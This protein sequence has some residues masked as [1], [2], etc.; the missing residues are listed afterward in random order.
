MHSRHYSNL[1]FS[2]TNSKVCSMDRADMAC[3]F[4][5]LRLQDS[6]PTSLTPPLLIF[7]S[8]FTY[9]GAI[10]DQFSLIQSGF[11]SNVCPTNNCALI[12][13]VATTSVVVR[14]C[15]VFD[16]RAER[17]MTVS[18]TNAIIT[19]TTFRDNVIPTSPSNAVL[20]LSSNGAST[21]SIQDNV[22]NNSRAAYEISSQGFTGG[23]PD[24]M[25]VNASFNFFV[26][27]TSEVTI[28]NR[29]Y[30]D[31]EDPNKPE[32]PFIPYLASD[33]V[34]ECSN[35]CTDRGV[36]V[37][38]AVV[39]FCVCDDGWGGSECQFPSCQR[40]NHCSGNGRCIAADNCDCDE[41]WLGVSCDRA[42]CTSRNECNGNG[43]CPLPD[44]CICDTSGGYTGRDCNDCLAGYRMIGAK[45]VECSICHNGGT[46]NDEAKCDCTGGFGGDDC[47]ICRENFFGDQCQALP[48]LESVLPNESLDE[49]ETTVRLI[50]VN[51]GLGG[52]SE[53]HCV[54]A[55]IGS[56]EAIEFDGELRCRTPRVDVGSAGVIESAI[57][58]SVD[59]Q[60]SFNSLS[61]TFYG[62][63][64]EGQCINGFCS[65]G[66]CRCLYGYRGD[67]CDE[68]L[69]A[70][71]IN[72]TPL[73][74]ILES[75]SFEHQLALKEGSEPVSWALIGLPPRG[76]SI[77]IDTGRFHWDDPQADSS[78]QKVT[79]QVQN[80]LTSS[81]IILRFHVRASYY[82]KVSTDAVGL[83][84]PSPQMTFSFQTVDALTH[85]LLPLRLAQLWIR[86]QGSLQSRST[87][88]RTNQFGVLEGT[89]QP[90]SND[91]G[92]F[93]YGAQH[94]T[95]KNSTVQGEFS[96][97][98]ISV[99][100]SSFFFRGLVGDTETVTDAFKFTFFGG[101]FSGIELAIAPEDGISLN[102]TLSSNIS[103]ET[104][105]QVFAGFSVNGEYTL[106][107][108]IPV[109]LKTN[110]GIEVSFSIY[111]DIRDRSPRLQLSPALIDVLVVQGGAPLYKDVS[112]KN[113]GSRGSDRID[114]VVPDQ[115][116]IRAVTDS[117]YP[118]LNVEEETT[119][120]FV[121][122]A[123]EDIAIGTVFE[124][125][126]GFQSRQ[127]ASPLNYR[128]TVVSE[129]PAVLT[130]VAT[131]EATYFT[132]EE[133]NLAN[134]TIT[135][136]NVNIGSSF[137]KSSGPSGT[138]VFDELVEG[139]YEVVA[140]KLGHQTFRQT[141]FLDSP[142]YTVEA[143]IQAA[144]VSYTF[145]V[146]PVEVL[147]KYI[148]IVE[149]TFETNVPRPVVV[150]EPGRLDWEGLRNGLYD[151]VS[152]T[153]TNYGLIAANDL[154]YRFFEYWE[155]VRFILPDAEEDP[156]Y[157]RNLGT[158][159]ANSSIVFTVEVEQLIQFDVPPDM[160]E[161]RVGNNV[162]FAPYDK[163]SYESGAGFI[164]APEDDPLDGQ[165][166][167]K[168]DSLG[169][170]D[171][172]YDFKNKIRYDFIYDDDDIRVEE[173]Y[174]ATISSASRR[175][176]GREVAPIPG[177][178][179][180][181][182]SDGVCLKDV[183][184]KCREANDQTKFVVCTLVPIFAV[185]TLPLLA[186]LA[187]V[188]FAVV[189]NVVLA[190]PCKSVCDKAKGKA[191]N[192]PTRSF[193]KHGSN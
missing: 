157:E 102:V 108:S 46:C 59:G 128:A 112:I 170:V 162:I 15:E 58:V 3:R 151:E 41:G 80:Q 57:R 185:F 94:P 124:G 190:D 114:I 159:P 179:V 184:D 155:N 192:L 76:T 47:R 138:A 6:L 148:V 19:E 173:V 187:A 177:R 60:L 36:C 149:T 168:L 55:G 70:P 174:N 31:D 121:F 93:E 85:Q 66:R 111:L 113:I 143:F 182:Q 18:S 72:P 17:I 107:G 160:V 125:T 105:Q 77:D 52:G 119:V 69:V 50:G 27:P 115:G 165:S 10:K 87:L 26:L 2:C 11:Y 75:V 30:D 34:A 117:V 16:S 97:R 86:P 82:V 1:L 127:A 186:K 21:F 126:I 20:Y 137:T 12:Y 5:D 63:C 29:I 169:N 116:I 37:A 188:A 166:Y 24:L 134:V 49:G 71:V 53:Y 109:A 8:P 120:S 135:I 132:E 98:G 139:F 35:N 123:T 39:A 100:P 7:S 103:N 28:D 81:R 164:F 172:V 176:M 4:G 13:L 67:A 43:Y 158:L 171:F 178:R 153:A 56:V 84:R 65:F 83:Q 79:V 96:I 150:W 48:F 68:A 141:I 154:T 142:G 62:L 191:K 129:V 133:P 183:C 146:V 54:F 140:Q 25:N 95:F 156:T 88:V 14:G 9:Q 101:S 78:E 32:V 118:G 181:Q 74:E 33:Y 38:S 90:Y 89:Y 130:V 161:L 189:C 91:A 51:L 122:S 73:F 167:L 104:S 175:L 22:F 193:A 136:R 110:E 99:L 163:A 40:L 45:C 152:I 64:P 145:R 106:S 61:F 144:Q 131:D 44:E 92:W 23:N 42:N 147:D 180:L